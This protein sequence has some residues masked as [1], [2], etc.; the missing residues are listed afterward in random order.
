IIQQ[1]MPI[2][3]AAVVGSLSRFSEIMR[4]EARGAGSTASAPGAGAAAPLPQPFA[5]WMELMR[6]VMGGQASQ[7]T[8]PAAPDPAAKPAPEHFRP[9][10]GGAAEPTLRHGVTSG[11]GALARQ[12][13]APPL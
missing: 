6:G 10:L 4:S 9:V 2:M 1:M 8:K 12:R 11:G 5:A 7:P 13:A 3:A